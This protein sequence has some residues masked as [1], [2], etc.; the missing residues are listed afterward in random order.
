MVQAVHDEQGQQGQGDKDISQILLPGQERG[1]QKVMS[2]IKQ[3]ERKD[4]QPDFQQGSPGESGSRLKKDAQRYK[5]E[6]C[7][8][9]SDIEKNLPFSE[10]VHSD[11]KVSIFSLR[12]SRFT[13]EKTGFAE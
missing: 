1:G 6:D 2:H 11:A 13:E 5:D 3:Q 8:P 9:A 7:Q 10:R 12:E 4:A